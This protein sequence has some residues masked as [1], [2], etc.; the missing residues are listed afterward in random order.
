MY[1][2]VLYRKKYRR[3]V[4]IINW[5]FGALQ[6]LDGQA[7]ITEINMVTNG[8]KKELNSFSAYICPLLETA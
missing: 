7:I 6:D 1:P 5:H 3:T 8:L 4:I 2:I